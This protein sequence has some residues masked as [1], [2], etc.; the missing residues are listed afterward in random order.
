MGI[1][2]NFVDIVV[3]VSFWRMLMCWVIM[4]LI[5]VEVLIVVCIVF[6]IGGFWC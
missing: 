3:M 4:R 6:F 2:E 1:R 5:G